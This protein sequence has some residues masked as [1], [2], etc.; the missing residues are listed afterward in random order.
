MMP[1]L[2]HS[3][4]SRALPTLTDFDGART[5]LEMEAGRR[6]PIEREH[7]VVRMTPERLVNHAARKEE[8]VVTHPHL[9]HGLRLDHEMVNPLELP[10]PESQRMMSRVGVHEGDV[11]LV[12]EVFAP[13]IV[14]QL[15]PEHRRVK[16]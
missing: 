8:A 14:A 1:P 13:D 10:S 11:D 2:A 5:K 4:V 7:P 9:L 12:S 6:V 16:R 15:Q 3:A